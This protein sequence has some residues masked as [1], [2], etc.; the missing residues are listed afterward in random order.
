MSNLYRMMLYLSLGTLHILHNCNIFGSEKVKFMH[1]ISLA[2]NQEISPVTK[3]LNEVK[4]SHFLSK[5]IYFGFWTD[6]FLDVQPAKDNF[7]V[8]LCL[9][10][11]LKSLLRLIFFAHVPQLLTRIGIFCL[12]SI[13]SYY[14]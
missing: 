5:P 7:Q 4:V 3:Y 9:V 6:T 10:L 11:E 13:P 14:P 1:D 8:Q 12:K 2:K